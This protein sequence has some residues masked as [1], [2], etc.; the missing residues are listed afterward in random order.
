MFRRIQT[1]TIDLYNFEVREMRHWPNEQPSNHPIIQSFSGSFVQNDTLGLRSSSFYLLGVARHDKHIQQ[2]SLNCEFQTYI[3]HITIF[4]WCLVG[5]RG[6]GW[7]LYNSY[8]SP[9]SPQF[10]ASKYINNF[11]DWPKLDVPPWMEEILHH[12]GW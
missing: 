4:Y 2:T 10:P 12:F 9:Y 5:N 8:R 6:M 3:L 11:P 7:W 1:L